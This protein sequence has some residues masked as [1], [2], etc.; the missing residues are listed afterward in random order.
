MH[1]RALTAAL[2]AVL[3]VASMATARTQAPAAGIPA[4]GLSVGA[5][6]A[7]DPLTYGVVLNSDE[8]GPVKIRLELFSDANDF[9]VNIDAV[10]FEPA[11]VAQPTPA[12]DVTTS[13]RSAPY[14]VRLPK[15]DDLIA[16]RAQRLDAA[17]APVA[18]C[19]PQYVFTD[20]WRSQA[21]PNFTLGDDAKAL[22]QSLRH[23]LLGGAPALAAIETTARTP[24]GSGSCPVRYAQAIVVKPENPVYPG[25]ARS[26]GAAGIAI[27]AVSLDPNGT[28]TETRVYKSSGSPDLDTAAS[29]AARRSIYRAE[30]FR[31]VPVS[32]TYMFRA[33]FNAS[34]RPVF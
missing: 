17:G 34:A 8:R 27:I 9:G 31:C 4:C 7:I 2:G 21:S 25:T 23:T 10:A 12:P 29:D 26:R 22:R 30:V 32:G 16:A 20:F 13:L 6:V 24:Q 14:F 3:L 18:S 1:S 15:A 19:A 28:V 5:I 33:E 11:P